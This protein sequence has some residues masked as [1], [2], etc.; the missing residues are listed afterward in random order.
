MLFYICVIFLLK[1]LT[2]LVYNCEH[3][4]SLSSEISRAVLVFLVLFRFSFIV[5]VL[6]QSCHC[7]ITPLS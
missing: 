1:L 6:L 3:C 7:H 2:Y 5:H 4:N